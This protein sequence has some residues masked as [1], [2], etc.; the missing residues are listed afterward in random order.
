[1][2]KTEPRPKQQQAIDAALARDGTLIDAK[3]GRGKT[4]IALS[5]LDRSKAVATL[6]IA[7]V[8]VRSVWRREVWKHMEGVDVVLPEKG[9]TQ[10]RAEQIRQHV[11]RA[12]VTRR[13]FIVVVNYESMWRAELAKVLLGVHWHLVIGDESQRSKSPS[14]KASRFL[15]KLKA[16]RRIGLTGTPTPHSPLDIWAQAQWIAPG[17]FQRTFTAFRAHYAVITTAPGFPKIIGWQNVDDLQ[18]R[19]TQFV[20]DCGD[21]DM[22]LPPVTD[23]VIDIELEPKAARA[24]TELERE[25]YARVDDGEITVANALAKILRLQQVTGGSIPTDDGTVVRIS[26]AKE[27]ALADILEDLQGQC[28]AVFCRF[29]SDLAAVR[30]AAEAANLAYGEIS[31]ATKDGL[32]HHALMRQDLDVVGVQVQSGGV[33]I[34]LTRANIGIFYSLTYSLGDYEQCKGRLHRPGQTRHT[35]F[36][37]LVARGTIDEKIM[38]ALEEKRDVIEAVVYG[39]GSGVH[40]AP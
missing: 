4:L 32:D 27:K 20:H 25:F 26:E 13:P 16:R 2:L 23:Q 22:N 7:P 34:D 12:R 17:V 35:H 28:V 40:R 33:G 1:M 19:L 8:S 9:T 31:G 11:E 30:S 18:D 5:I 37:H 39:R 38:A 21:E 10:R 3:V 24:Y 14:G 29:K 6:V 15:R 36:L